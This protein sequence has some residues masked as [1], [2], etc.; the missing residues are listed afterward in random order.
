MSATGH[1]ATKLPTTTKPK[2]IDHSTIWSKN[3]PRRL[4]SV[5]KALRQAFSSAGVTMG[6][7]LISIEVAE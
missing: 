1:Q 2:K 5:M 7:S 3:V 6:F 4:A